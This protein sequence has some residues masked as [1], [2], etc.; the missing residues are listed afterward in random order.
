MNLW[1]KFR[2]V[3]GA[4]KRNG[5][6]EAKPVS[7]LLNNHKPRLCRLRQL[8]SLPDTHYLKLY[9]EMIQRF[10]ELVQLLPASE[11]HHHAYAGGLLQHALETAEAALR[12]RQHYLLPQGGIPEHQSR[13]ADLYTYAVFSSALIHDIGKPLSDMTIL[14][15]Q[16]DGSQ[17]TWSPLGGPMK[18]GTPYTIRFDRNRK[19]RVH[20]RLPLL[21]VQWIVPIE[22]QVWLSSE[23]EVLEQWTAALSGI[24]LDE[25]G[26]IGEIIKKA[27]QYSVLNNLTGGQGVVVA[28]Q[29]VVPLHQRLV[30]ELKRL[31]EEDWTANKPGAVCFIEQNADTVWLVSKRALDELRASML[32]QGQT[33]IPPNPRIMDELMQHDYLQAS[34]DGKAVRRIAITL[35]DWSQTLSCLGLRLSKVWGDTNRPS[36][37]KEVHI[38]YE[39]VDLPVANKSQ[40][41]STENGTNVRR[42]QSDATTI[43]PLSNDQVAPQTETFLASNT[44]E[45]ALFT[46]EWEKNTDNSAE[47]YVQSEQGQDLAQ[48]FLSWIGRGISSGS[49]DI[50]NAKAMLHVV[51]QGL[52]IVSPRIFRVF[53]KQVDVEYKTV[54]N[55]F[56]RLRINLKTEQGQNIWSFD[57]QGDRKSSIIKGMIIMQPKKTLGLEKLPDPNTMLV[58]AKKKFLDK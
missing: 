4:E 23:R 31:V 13:T 19:Y 9:V 45:T 43:Q 20:E 21:L 2:F 37:H 41:E 1:Q 10:A 16:D 28:H 33:G 54:Q 44:Q 46:D 36:G 49:L 39:G 26:T 3:F 30:T 51:P 7:K 47:D 14:M 38:S 58:L 15:S 5:Y 24:S 12:I 29:A 35:D 32:G 42:N 55:K 50:N 27:D 25:V 34:A 48:S 18:T 40:D 11:S 53:A 22:G 57:V 8:T 6:L 17:V 52:L 56:Q